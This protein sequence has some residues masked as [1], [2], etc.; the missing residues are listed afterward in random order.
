MWPRPFLS[1]GWG[2]GDPPAGEM[3]LRVPGVR[4]SAAGGGP[5]PPL[6]ASA[7]CFVPVRSGFHLSTWLQPQC[8][9]GRPT[10]ISVLAPASSQGRTGTGTRDE[11]SGSRGVC[12]PGFPDNCQSAP[13]TL[14]LPPPVRSPRVF[15]SGRI[16]SFLRFAF[17][18]L[19]FRSL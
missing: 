15:A 14:G 11:V 7:A 5:G 10:A 1:V 3:E 16:L 17:L 4:A 18:S 19:V 6:P 8:H 12:P 9:H 13:A 2:L